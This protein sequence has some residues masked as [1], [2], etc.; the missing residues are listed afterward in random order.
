MTTETKTEPRVIKLDDYI[1][2]LGEPEIEEIRTLAGKLTG[3]TVQMV[4]STAMGGGVA[5]ILNRLIPL[6][7]ELGLDPRWDVVTGGEDFF[8]VTKAFHNALHG[9]PYQAR[10]ENFDVFLA[11]S[12]ANRRRL[13]FDCEFTVMHDPQPVA[14]IEARSGHAGHWIWRC[15][16]DLSHPNQEVWGFLRP[17]IPSV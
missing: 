4:N 9:G 3:R 8:E 15:H 13:Q 16:I 1:T 5:E 2:L 12:D 6:M 14:L 10:K 17:Y 11:T 7:K